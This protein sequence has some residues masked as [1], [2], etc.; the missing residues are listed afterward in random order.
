MT[1]DG[2]HIKHECDWKHRENNIE[3][4]NWIEQSCSI[5]RRKRQIFKG[6]PHCT[7]W[8]LPSGLSYYTYE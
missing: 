2:I 4:Q 1:D 7:Y 3:E 8:E 6:R 5:C